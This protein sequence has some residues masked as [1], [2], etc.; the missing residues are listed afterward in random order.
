MGT[1]IR[2]TKLI[3]KLQ[4]VVLTDLNTALG[5]SQNQL[6]VRTILFRI[7]GTV[8]ADKFTKTQK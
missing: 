1:L 7:L 3:N 4:W 2:H 6:P 5:S 8:V